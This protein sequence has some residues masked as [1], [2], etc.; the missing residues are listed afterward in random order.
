MSVAK[1]TSK[2]QVTIPSDI[3]EAWQIEPGDQLV[4]YTGSNG[5]LNVRV[6]RPRVGAGRGVIA[7]DGSPISRHATGQAVAEAVDLRRKNAARA[8]REDKT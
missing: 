5:R 6:R 1:V 2:G 3:R 7:H 8:S 4:F